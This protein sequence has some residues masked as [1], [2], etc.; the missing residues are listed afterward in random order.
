MQKKEATFYIMKKGEV[1]IVLSDAQVPLDCR[2]VVLKAYA[3]AGY[4]VFRERHPIP[5]PDP[6]L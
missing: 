5:G 3:K 1:V 6:Q 4:D 2:E